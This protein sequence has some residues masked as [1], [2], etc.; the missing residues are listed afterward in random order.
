MNTLP[1]HDNEIKRILQLFDLSQKEEKVLYFSSDNGRS[2]GGADSGRFAA[3]NLFCATAKRN[4][5][6]DVTEKRRNK[7]GKRTERVFK[8]N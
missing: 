6:A 1:L 8:G 3:N 2:V 4:V 7:N 5:F